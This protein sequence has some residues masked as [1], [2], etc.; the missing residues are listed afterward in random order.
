MA[1]NLLDINIADRMG[2]YNPLQNS[3]DLRNSYELKAIL[4]RLHQEEGQFKP[5][6]LAVNGTILM[7]ALQIEAGP[8]LGELLD[9]AF[10]RVLNNIEERNTEKEIL[11]YLKN[12]LKNRKTSHER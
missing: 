6:D 3:A 10:D 12:Y 1:N 5:A 7:Q 2:Q 9:Q 8:L 4:K 11:V